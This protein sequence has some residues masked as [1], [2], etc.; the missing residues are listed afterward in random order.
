MSAISLKSITGITSI[1]TPAG[2]DNQLTLHN[3]N[4]TEAVKLDVAG[5]IH[6]H[7]HLNITGVST[8]SNFKTGTSN[9]HN[10][11]L[12]VQDLD[13]DGHT[14]LDNVSIAGVTTFSTSPVVPNG[15]FYKGVINSGSQEKIVG[16]YTSGTDTLRLGESMYLLMTGRLG[17]NTNNP[18]R[19]IHVHTTGSGSDYMQFTNDTTG[20]S[21]SDGYVF[22]ISGT[23]DVIHNNFEST[24][25]NFFTAGIERFRIDSSGH[26][27]HTGIR[28]G[29]SENKL[30]IL[31]APSY[32]TSEED[33]I[34][35]QAENEVSSNQLSIGGGTSSRN[36]VTALSFRTASAVNTTGGDERL[37]IDS[38][39]NVIIAE[40]MAVNR[41]RIV[42]SAPNDGTNYRHLF[43]A[44]LQVNS[45]GT[46]TTP[47]AN[48]SGGGWEYLAAN[49]INQHGDIRYLSAPDTNATT[50]TP[51]ER[52]RITSE[53][54][55][56][57]GGHSAN[58]DVGGLSA[59]MVHLEG[60]SG[61]ASIS[62]INNQNSGGNSALYLGKSRGT[63]IGSNVILQEDDPMGSIVWCGSDGND[64]IS[65]GAV[66]TAQVDGTP[67]SNDMPGRLVFKTTAD[68][69]ATPTERLRITSG[70]DLLLGNHGSRIFDDSSGT[71]VVVD[72]YGGTTAGKRGILALGG[73]TGS[74]NADIGTIQF[75]NENNN[76]ATAANH[77]QSK[78]VASIDVKSETS[79]GNA[80]SDSGAHLLFNTKPETGEIT[81][82]LRISSLGNI[83]QNLT[84]PSGTSPFQNS[85]WYD[86]DGGN[87]TLTATDDNSFTAVRTSS[88]G[89]YNDLVYKR[90]RM[91]KN[92]DI[93]FELSGNSPPNTYRHV[94]FVINGDG[95]ATHSNW[96]RLVFRSRPASTSN[97]QI[98]IDKGGGGYGF[99]EQGS[100]IPTFFDGTERHILIQ[101]RDRLVNIIVDGEVIISQKTNADFNRSQGW[102][103]FGIY[104]GGESAQITIRNLTIKNK[105]IQPHWLVRATGVNVD[106]NNGDVLPFNQVIKSS[107]D[108]SNTSHYNNSSYRFNVP[109][110]GLYYVFV[111]AYRNS[112]SGSEVAFYVNGSVRNRF[113]PLP[114][115]GDYIFAGSALI[116][117]MKGEYIDVRAYNANFGNFYG[118]SSQ[119]FSS[120]GG[121]LID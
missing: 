51:V 87:Y 55:I 38:T 80:G 98:R 39:G 42:L 92:C 121:H 15:G 28:S 43:G 118:N 65:Q 72:I 89:E 68:G 105:F 86:R 56:K 111:R 6:F 116:Q 109:I 62:L 29:N 74:D 108:M 100:Y 81:E 22:G 3:N 13:V 70:G 110:S 54:Y 66:I 59:Q 103:G 99:N 37:R 60:T 115:G 16:G 27:K 5:N 24:N 69:A 44:N 104:E 82:R 88:G 90:V 112:S 20:T 64:M 71:N 61:A 63:S 50:S 77:V 26:L 113:R 48:I 114:N 25:M 12:N 46:F 106:V 78:L 93:E 41:P 76:L 36:A 85:H 45:S 94:G 84:S 79:D 119:A 8:A 18:Q 19:R 2:V 83:K 58:R 97:N 21:A 73:R 33:V 52:L 91:S 102:F 23:E 17:L 47:T 107:S 117:L 67:G 31:S 1:T 11:G 49:S 32:N 35:Y 4:T 75:V 95:T 40:S 96:D 30:A 7:N 14:N 57:I 120:W 9:L 10:T 101:L 53:G 34:I